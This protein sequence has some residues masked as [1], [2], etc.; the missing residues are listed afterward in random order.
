MH[1]KICPRTCPSI[2]RV[3]FGPVLLRRHSSFLLLSSRARSCSASYSSNGLKMEI[4]PHL[5]L[6]ADLSQSLLRFLADNF[7]TIDS[8]SKTPD[9]VSDLQNQCSNLDQTLTDLN[10]RL[11]SNISAYDSHSDRIGR[12]FGE[13]RARLSDFRSSPFVSATIPG[14]DL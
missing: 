6:V 14:S 11:C 12:V 1:L 5:P 13:I 10:Q 8:L 4:S 3:G 9:I 7:K 2:G